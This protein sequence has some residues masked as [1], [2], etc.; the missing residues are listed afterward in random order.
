[1][2]LVDPFMPIR[3]IPRV[4]VV[5]TDDLAQR[6]GA[7]LDND[8]HLFEIEDASEA[9]RVIHGKTR[10]GAMVIITSKTTPDLD[11]IV[12]AF[13]ASSRD[14]VFRLIVITGES[15]AYGKRIVTVSVEDALNGSLRQTV[16]DIDAENG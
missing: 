5:S 14:K 2:S 9:I 6:A 15:A 3:S 7:T 13:S 16:R 8:V 10:K 11:R 4:G 12:R 1:M